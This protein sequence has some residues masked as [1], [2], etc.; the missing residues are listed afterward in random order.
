MYATLIIGGCIIKLICRNCFHQEASNSNDFYN[1]LLIG[2]RKRRNSNAT[3]Y[4][5]VIDLFTY[6]NNCEYDVYNIGFSYTDE[7]IIQYKK[8]KNSFQIKL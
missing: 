8:T 6:N 4:P 7:I 3:T 5:R 2:S 1:K